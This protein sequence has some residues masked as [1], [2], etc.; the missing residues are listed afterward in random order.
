MTL[1][2]QDRGLWHREEIL[3]AYALLGGLR[4]GG[5]YG[6]ELRLQAL[7]AAEHAR[8]PTAAATDW[9]TI[10]GVYDAL[11]ALTGS[12]VVRLN[13]AVAVGEARGPR[14]GLALLEGLEDLLPGSHRLAAVRGEL[15][16]RAGE[17]ACALASLA[18]AI[19]LCGNDV[20]RAHLRSRLME[21]QARGR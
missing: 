19:E 11:E 2:E 4:P 14:A 5:G 16:H 13:R 1:A 20:E 7:I 9:H 18:A 17:R 21:I 12:P 3:T 6:E 10:A 15:A 8:A